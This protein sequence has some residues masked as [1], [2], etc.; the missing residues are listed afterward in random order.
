MKSPVEWLDRAGARLRSLL[1]EDVRVL[2]GLAPAIV[3]IALAPFLAAWARC[4]LKEPV[5]SNPL[6]FQYTGWCIRHGLRL[7]RDVGMTDGPFIHY[8]Q[9]LMQVFAGMGDRGFRKAD[10]AL[11]VAGSGIMGAALAPAERSGRFA[12]SVDRFVWAAVGATLWLCWYFTFRWDSDGER[13]AFYGLFGSTGLA[14]LFASGSGSLRG[15]KVCTVIGAV[16]VTS[17]VFGK[18]TGVMYPAAG[19]LSLVLPNAEAPLP[20]RSRL[21]FFLAGCAGCVAAVLLLLLVS[22]SVPGYFHWC[23]RI[24]WVGNRFLFRNNWLT[25]LLTTYWERFARLTVLSLVGG[26]AAIA[27]GLVPLRGIGIVILP[28]IAFVGACLQGRGYDYH[29]MPAIGGV[30]LVLLLVVACA[31]KQGHDGWSPGRGAVAAAALLFAGAHSFGNLLESTF[32]WNGEEAKWDVAEHQSGEPEKEVGRYIEAH[33]KPDDWVFAYDT[34]CNA[35]I[36]LLAAERRTASPYMQAYYLDPV[37]LLS[38]SRVQPNAVELAALTKLQTDDR[39]AA[40]EG[41][42]RHKPAAMALTSV[43]AAVELCP[44]V[45]DMLAS[46]F[47]LAT[48]LKSYQI[49]L[50]KER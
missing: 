24:P 30:H 14:L 29:V 15:A 26:V 19:L 22:G 2:R 3:P 10:L 49:Y 20:W 27:V 31:W 12:R 8:L 32:R 16:L 5:F 1:P 45:R 7:Y 48:T 33:T 9:A 13:E 17:Q 46:D 38:Q 25:Y 35:H 6:V 21:R 47:D 28:T 4:E 50:R 34:C 37:G 43:D 44:V 42:V 36:V 39:N 23:W 40:C 18:P 11:Q 41:I